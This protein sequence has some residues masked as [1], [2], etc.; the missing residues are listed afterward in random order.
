MFDRV[1]VANRGEIACRIIRACRALGL[2]TVAVYSEA[3]DKALHVELADAAHP[4]GPAKAADSYLNVD[5]ILTAARET[6]AEAV[7]PGYGFLAENAEFARAVADAGLT[8][9][10]PKPE[11]ITDMGDK[12]RAR[13]LAKGAGVPVLPGS[14]RYGPGDI[15]GIADVAQQI[16]F[17]LLVK[18]SAGGG[19]IGMRRIDDPSEL[20]ST[21]TATQE[22]AEKSFGDGTVYLEKLIDPARHVEIQVFGFGDGRAV[23]LFER[24]CSIQRRFQKVVEE[25]PAPGL[26]DEVRD[27]MAAAAVALAIQERYRG[28]GTVEFVVGPDQDFYFLEMNTRIQVEHPVTEMRTGID[29]V[30]SQILLA[31]GDPVG[32]VEQSD[33][34]VNGH[35]VECR[36]YAEKPEMK[37]VPSPGP[38]SLYAPPE[39]SEGLRIDDGVREGDQVTFHYDPMIAKLVAH[40][41]D[42]NAALDRMGRALDDFRVDGISTNIAFLRNLMD[43]PRFRAGDTFTGFVESHLADLV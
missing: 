10:G 32:H 12:E 8:W 15:A 21:V 42:R 28:A 1:L 16:G 27:A 35:A 25:S 24:E 39:E 41:S 19:G 31:R 23:H 2:E 4:I 30:Q 22:L 17:P 3:D 34:S 5:S 11:T 40:G 18:A 13:L 9:I 29:L 6:E 37:F 7:H 43:H 36:I 14:P 38:L 20:E 26:R 33:V